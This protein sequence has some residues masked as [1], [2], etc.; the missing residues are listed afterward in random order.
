LFSISALIIRRSV[1]P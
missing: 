1:P